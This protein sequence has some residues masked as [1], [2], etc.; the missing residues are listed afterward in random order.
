M[1]QPQAFPWMLKPNQTF[2]FKQAAFRLRW[3]RFGAETTLSNLV[4][5]I[6]DEEASRAIANKFL[7][8]TFKVLAAPQG[9]R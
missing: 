3:I 9:P 5:L 6:S 1:A 7:V 2:I 8:P 4:I